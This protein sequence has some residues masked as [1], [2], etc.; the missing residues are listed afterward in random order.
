METATQRSNGGG[1]PSLRV[2]GPLTLEAD[3]GLVDLGGPRQ[4]AVLGLLAAAVGGAVSIDHLIDQLWEDRAPGGPRRTVQTYVSNLRRVLEH[5]GGGI[6]RDGEAYRLRLEP[7]MVDLYRY[8]QELVAA[9]RAADP[10]LALTHRR[11]ATSEWR[12]TPFTG[13]AETRQLL[14]LTSELEERHLDHETRR[15]RLEAEHGDTA[16]A[17]AQLEAITEQAPWL[18]DNW[19][20][21]ADLLAARGRL[22]E[23][24]TRADAALAREGLRVP[25]AIRTRVAELADRSSRE[26]TGTEYRLPP[27]LVSHLR[28]PILGRLLEIATIERELE[29]EGLGLVVIDGE[30]GVGKTRLAA[31]IASRSMR[32][33]APVLFGHADQALELPLQPLLETVEFLADQSSP[34]TVLEMAGPEG[35]EF[36]HLTPRFGTP[37][38]GTDPDLQTHWI[39]TATARLL[40]TLGRATPVIWVVDDLQWTDDAFLQLLTHLVTHQPDL[41]LTIVATRRV[42]SSEQA[43]RSDP[44]LH[45][46]E[47]AGRLRRLELGGLDPV[48]IGTLVGPENREVVT[49]YTGGNALYVS[50]VARDLAAGGEV[51]P[52]R[53]LTDTVIQRARRLGADVSGALTDASVI[54]LRF[55]AETL[56]RATGRDRHEVIRA[57]DAAVE[58]QLL[59]PRGSD[60][61]EYEFQHGLVRDALYHAMPAGTR[62]LAHHDVAVALEEPL[63]VADPSLA[64]ELAHHWAAAAPAGFAAEAISA[65]RHAAALAMGTPRRAAA[66]DLLN[67]AVELTSSPRT[68]MTVR[69]ETLIELAEAHAGTGDP[70]SCLDV[71]SRAA[72]LAARAGLDHL[73]ARAALATTGGDALGDAFRA[74]HARAL[75]G[76]GISHVERGGQ[77]WALLRSKDLGL[78]VWERRAED[79]AA[80]FAELCDAATSALDPAVRRQIVENGCYIVTGD[81]QE[82]CLGLLEGA[83]EVDQPATA[84]PALY[85]RLQTALAV[86]DGAAFRAV[87]DEYRPAAEGNHLHQF[88]AGSA[89]ATVTFWDGDWRSGYRAL[90]PEVEASRLVRSMGADAAH[91]AWLTTIAW[92][93]DRPE[94]ARPIVSDLFDTYRAAFFDA[95]LGWID[96]MAGSL[97]RIRTRGAQRRESYLIP[98]TVP[99]L[100]GL[101]LWPFVFAA[102]ESGDG[103]AIDFAWEMVLTVDHVDILSMPH[104][105][106]V[107]NAHLK[108]LL[109][110]A[111][112]DHASAAGE[113]RTA[114]AVYERLGARPY[115]AVAEAELA[116]SLT[117]QG[118]SADEVLAH[119]GVAGDLARQHRLRLPHRLAHE[120]QRIVA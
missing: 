12:G 22:D 79:Q 49:K 57:L 40:R 56:I 105:P 48:S 26:S 71:A 90:V 101:A 41:P 63:R 115:I 1:G 61:L 39:A 44:M 38:G 43:V 109:H 37:R 36:G 18:T 86:A 11:S 31:E 13:I 102:A 50:E 25:D 82:R 119:A 75:I 93:A 116:H 8:E 76:R 106:Q 59:L 113:W 34:G 16:A 91:A 60:N 10:Q 114:I 77:E 23:V 118:A 53:Y 69:C 5:V 14:A 74:G 68:E 46:F 94:I 2:L 103:A 83:V 111:S 99:R 117:R 80:D 27:A 65:L 66:V 19:L 96:S 58:S 78:Q 33:G 92:L 84:L 67:R 81:L 47:A 6:D 87:L 17:V 54:G 64:A 112:G 95:Q 32:R 100:S 4:R 15:L 70:A 9:E 89:A 104:H 55:E 21:L 88:A 42:E 120:A 45:R 30:A 98:L 85:E 7:A 73:I 24:P 51:G 20:T 97:D 28:G 72:D 108:A 3:T 110:A 107:A 29:E 52:N 62:A 35:S